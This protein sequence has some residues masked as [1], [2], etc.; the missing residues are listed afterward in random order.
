MTIES[1]LNGEEELNLL[2]NPSFLWD[3]NNYNIRIRDNP[4]S[5]LYSPL[6]VDMDPFDYVSV[7]DI[8]RVRNTG[9][10]FLL[11]LLITLLVHLLFLAYSTTSLELFWVFLNAL[12]IIDYIILLNL[13]YPTTMLLTFKYFSFTN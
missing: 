7:A 1:S 12:Q 13:N 8:N 3:V 4:T 10:T 5:T 11:A 2:V 9:Y 6:T